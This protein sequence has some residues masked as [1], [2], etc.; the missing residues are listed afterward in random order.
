MSKSEYFRMVSVGFE[1]VGFGLGYG[2]H[3]CTPSGRRGGRTHSL[4]GSCFFF[5][6]KKRKKKQGTR[7]PLDCDSPKGYT[8]VTLAF[9]L[10][11][12]RIHQVASARDAEARQART[13]VPLPSDTRDT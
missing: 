1:A 11:P 9:P 2:V 8:C 3:M 6:V 12:S 7:V 5:K 13:L 10:K 4:F